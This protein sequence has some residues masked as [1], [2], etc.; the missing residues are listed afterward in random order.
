MRTMLAVLLSLLITQISSGTA[1]SAKDLA[2]SKI[3]DF[4]GTYV[5]QSDRAIVKGV[6]ARDASVTIRANGKS[7]FHLSWK[8]VIRRTARKPKV[9]SYA[10]AFTRNSKRGFLYASA[11]KKNI[12]GHMVP[13]DPLSGD[14]YVWASLQDKTLTVWALFIIDDGGYEIQIYKRSLIPGGLQLR[15]E[16]VRNGKTKKLITATLKK[17]AN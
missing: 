11:M 5:G 4:F 16:R 7:G 6:A 12:F 3:N 9:K 14:P 2:Q 15:F 8:T 10:I 1:V 17:T 13:L